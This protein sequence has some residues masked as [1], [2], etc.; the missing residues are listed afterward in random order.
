MNLI[1]NAHLPKRPTP[2]LSAMALRVRDA[3]FAH[4]RSLDLGAWDL[5][6]RAAAMELNIPGIH[7]VGDSLIYF[8]DRYQDFSIY[9]VDF[10]PLP[11]ADPRPPALA[12]LHWFGVVQAILADRTGD[13]LDFYQTLFGFAV[14]P[15]GQYFGV[16]PKGTLLESP[17]HKFYLQ[18]IEPPP[19]SEDVRWEEGLVRVGLGAPGRPARDPSAEGAR[20]RVHR[21]RRGAAERQGRAHPGVPGR[22]DLRAGRESPRAMNLD[23]FGMDTI[24]LAGPLEAEAAGDARGRLHPDH[25]ERLRHRR[26]SGRRA[27]GGARRC[28]RAACASPA[29]RC[30]ATS[31]AS[32]VTCTP[33][34]ST[35]PRRCSR[36]AARSARGCCW[37]ARRR[38]RH[39]TRRDRRPGQG[40]AE[41]RDAGGAA[42]HPR[43]LRGAVL[44]PARQRVPAGLGASSRDGRSR[45][46][47]LVPRLVPHPGR[48]TAA[49]RRS[50]TSIPARCS[51]CS[52]RTSCGRRCAR[53]EERIDTARHFRVFPGEG[54][55]SEQVAELVR[56]STRRDTAATTASRC[57]T[58]TT[59]AA[60]ADGRRAR[61]PLGE[62]DH[63]P[64]VAPE[65]AAAA[66][67]RA[68]RACLAMS[69]V[70]HGPLGHVDTIAIGDRRS[71]VPAR[72]PSRR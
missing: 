51:S 37:S 65:P 38:R 34:R 60:P 31:R 64:G 71:S 43:R 30:C 22:R 20:H 70:A 45:Q 10:V 35:S 4:Q 46:P 72:R 42:R 29:S 21:S 16:L 2:A 24:T 68:R 39:A 19:G 61:A 6:T 55:H 5:P 17:C 40:P 14:L 25:A 56:R 50:P 67:G 32:P 13:W 12:G 63:R 36:C 52:S 66:A 26:P 57:S 3:A 28:G 27:G 48:T 59:A 58:T 1:V 47:R 44:G 11:G 69:A 18:L 8:V 54:V 33:T 9:D 41:A 15:Q 62:V 7:G 23:H 49:W 53:R